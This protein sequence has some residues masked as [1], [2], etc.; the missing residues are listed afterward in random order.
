MPRV[1]TGKEDIRGITKTARAAVCYSPLEISYRR[2]SGS[3]MFFVRLKIVWF[4]CFFSSRSQSLKLLS[5]MAAIRL[6]DEP[7]NI[8]ST[9]TLALMDPKATASTNKSITADP[10]ASS[11]W[12]KVV[13]F[14]HRKFTKL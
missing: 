11:S 10:L 14:T 3:P 8:E 4:T 7:D 9:L 2:N 1:W 13:G 6:E 5:I 12:D